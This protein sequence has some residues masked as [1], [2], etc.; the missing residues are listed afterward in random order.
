[1]SSQDPLPGDGD[2]LSPFTCTMLMQLVEGQRE[3]GAL[4]HP[5]I[6]MHDEQCDRVDLSSLEVE[7]S[8]FNMVSFERSNLS[9][10]HLRVC[11]FTRCNLHETNFCLSTIESGILRRCDA[12]HA[13]LSSCDLSDTTFDHCTLQGASFTSSGLSGAKF[14]GYG[15]NL[16]RVNFDSATMVDCT[17]QGANLT[18]ST[19]SLSN[20]T[21]ADFTTANLSR[22]YFYCTDLSGADLRRA[23]LTGATLNNVLLKGTKFTSVDQIVR[24]DLNQQRQAVAK[25][26]RERRS[27]MI[28]LG[29]TIWPGRRPIVQWLERNV[30]TD[31]PP[32]WDTLARWVSNY[33][34]SVKLEDNPPIV[35]LLQWIN[36]FTQTQC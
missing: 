29:E 32:E 27:A 8:L 17:L 34:L 2:T 14:W 16:T 5:H 24:A 19:F 30:P 21:G 11:D 23:D 35:L 25:C 10:S 26:C 3:Y 36:E 18:E 6:V 22:A 7:E 13:N 33:D 9:G 28:Q 1:M 20:C 12:E 15:A 4:T 31:A